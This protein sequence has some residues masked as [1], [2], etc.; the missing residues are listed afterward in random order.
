MHSQRHDRDSWCDGNEPSRQRATSC[1]IE[2]NCRDEPS[3]TVCSWQAHWKDSRSLI[4]AE[5]GASAPPQ[6]ARA[7]EAGP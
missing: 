4:G 5:D 2:Q 3:V 7:G 1:R 6:A